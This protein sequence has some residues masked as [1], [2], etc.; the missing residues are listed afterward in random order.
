[1]KKNVRKEQNEHQ[2]LDIQRQGLSRER[3]EIGQLGGEKKRLAIAN[4]A[5]GGKSSQPVNRQL[6]KKR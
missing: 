6:A 1:M 4:E 5:I 3:L 2:L